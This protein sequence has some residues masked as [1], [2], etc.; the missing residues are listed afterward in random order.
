MADEARRLSTML[1]EQWGCGMGWARLPVLAVMYLVTL[2]FASHPGVAKGTGLVFVSNEKGNS[3]TVLDGAHKVVETFVTCARPR[4][5]LF[6]PD[7]SGI[8][9]ACGDDDI[10]ALYDIASRKL[11]KRYRETPD[12]ETFDLHPDGKHLYVANEED[13]VANSI[14]IATGEIVASLATSEEPEGVKVSADGK[15]VFVTSETDNLVHV[16]D[17]IHMRPIKDVPVGSRPRR[18]ALSPDGKELWV[19]AELSGVIDIIDTTTLASSGRVDLQ[20]AGIAKD[21]VTPVDIVI[22]RDGAKAYVAL[23]RSNHIAAIDVKTR[24]VTGYTMA[25]LRPWGLALNHD[26]SLLYVTNGWSNDVSI[27]ET[28]TSRKLIDVPVG[29]APYAVLIDD[30]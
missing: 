27:I 3:I 15:T 24:A 28:A 8:F 25:G 20:P 10:I 26:E 9:V 12:P 2:A 17:A 6:H 30:Q 11:I 16:I 19:S 13:S 1:M 4:G 7:H 14:D 5:M 21:Q 29:E 23:G 22:T 18:L